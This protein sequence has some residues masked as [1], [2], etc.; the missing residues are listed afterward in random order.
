MAL[1]QSHARHV[2]SLHEQEHP[3]VGDDACGSQPGDVMLC[4]IVAVVVAGLP[5][6]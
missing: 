2:A 3:H 4:A 1:D 5:V 6:C